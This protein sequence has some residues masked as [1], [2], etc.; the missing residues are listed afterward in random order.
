MP[1]INLNQ[2]KSQNDKNVSV[3]IFGK[4]LS[5]L[6]KSDLLLEL[7]FG[8]FV[9]RV[10]K[11]KK[12]QVLRSVEGE[13]FALVLDK[14]GN[15]VVRCELSKIG[16]GADYEAR[17]QHFRKRDKFVASPQIHRNLSTGSIEYITFDITKNAGSMKPGRDPQ[18]VPVYENR[19]S[20]LMKV[21]KSAYKRK[22]STVTVT[23]YGTMFN[24]FGESQNELNTNTS[25]EV[26]EVFS[27]Q[28]YGSN[29]RSIEEVL[30]EFGITL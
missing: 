6:A 9:F 22:A 24:T 19:K 23:I 13:S 7:Q 20:A 25:A 12:N 16:C 17:Y 5:F 2:V 15:L 3:N 18:S 4:E 11:L 28:I 30:L 8:E 21:L 1:Y 27:E 10:V 26:A 14:S 29:L